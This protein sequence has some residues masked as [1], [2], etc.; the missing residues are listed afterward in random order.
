MQTSSALST[1][2]S[3]EGV[4][5]A[6]REVVIIERLSC[7]NKRQRTKAWGL[8]KRCE[9]MQT[10]HSVVLRN[11]CSVQVMEA[12]AKIAKSGSIIALGDCREER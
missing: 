4:E 1:E 12:I 3:C 9:D 8:C 11:A 5:P 7:G 10:L 2:E 6:S